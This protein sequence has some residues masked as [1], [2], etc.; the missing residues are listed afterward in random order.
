MLASSC[1][2]KIS[3]A[4]GAHLIASSGVVESENKALNAL[5]VN[6]FQKCNLLS[7]PAAGSNVNTSINARTPTN[8]PI[9]ANMQAS[10]AV[11]RRRRRNCNAIIQYQSVTSS[12]SNET[13]CYRSVAVNAMPSANESAC[14]CYTFA[15]VSCVNPNLVANNNVHYANS[16]LRLNRD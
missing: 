15:P 16:D 5:S 12:N 10:N 8:M 13:G 11:S 3:N 2:S 7:R 4:H 1:A 14:A 6:N 9:K